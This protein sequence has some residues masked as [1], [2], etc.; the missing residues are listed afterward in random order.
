PMAGQASSSSSSGG[1][2]NG[3]ASNDGDREIFRELMTVYLQKSASSNVRFQAAS[4]GSYYRHAQ[5]KQQNG[6]SSNSPLMQELSSA[7]IGLTS[8]YELRYREKLNDLRSNWVIDANCPRDSFR[9]VLDNVFVDN[10]NWGRVVTIFVFGSMFLS[11]CQRQGIS[12]VTAAE[13]CDWSVEY[14]DKRVLQWINQNGG[15][16]GLIRFYNDGESGGLGNGPNNNNNDSGVLTRL[17]TVAG[18]GLAIASLT[19]FLR[20]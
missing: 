8:D 17:L 16:L 7:V 5:Q 1:G 18:A 13:V 4:N 19:S 15:W 3:G 14:V 9:Q 20:A 6:K 10:C 12:G 11:Q 2:S